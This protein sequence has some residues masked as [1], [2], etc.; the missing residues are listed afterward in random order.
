MLLLGLAG[1]APGV[2]FGDAGEFIAAAA[3]L[4]IAHAPG[5]PLF[6]LAAKAFGTVFAFGTWAL[7]VNLFSVL[8][9]AGAGAVFL[10]A[11]ARAGLGRAGRLFAVAALCLAPVWLHN[12]LQTEVFALNGLIAAVCLWI[13]VR[14]RE[15]FFEP[16]PAA[17][18][19]LALGLG[20]ANHQ[21]LIFLLP[22]ILI[23]AWLEERRN[24]G[25]PSRLR[26]ARF[27]SHFLGF[28]LLGL[29]VYAYLPIRSR[30]GPALDWGHPVDFPS[31]LHVLLRRDYGSFALTVQ[32]GETGGLPAPISQT[33]RFLAASWSGLGPVAASAALAGAA[34]SRGRGAA[35]PLALLLVAGPGFLIL[36][37]PPFDPI[38]AGAL[39]RF[40]LLPWFGAAWLAGLAVH[41]LAMRGVWARRAAFALLLAPVLGAAG[42]PAAWAQRWDLAAHDYGRNL[43][44]SLPPGAVL[45]ID[46]GDDSFYTLANLLYAERRRPD[47]E[48]HDR[49]GLVFPNAYGTQFRKLPKEAKEARRRFVES[50]MAD[51]GRAVFYATL[52]RGLLPDRALPIRGLL[53]R[54]GSAGANPDA[55]TEDPEG[56]ALWAVYPLRLSK[57]RAKQYYRY[58]ALIPFYAVM[59]AQSDESAGRYATALKRLDDAADLGGDAAWLRSTTAGIA[60]WIGFRASGEAQWAAAVAAYGLSAR[61]VGDRPDGWLNLGVAL[62][63]LGSNREAERAYRRAIAADDK[64]YRA[65]YNLGALY[66]KEENWPAAALA[67]DRAVAADPARAD[68]RGY[69]QRARANAQAGR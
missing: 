50:A 43:T 52:N 60:E 6:C 19:G 58:R 42:R 63:R 10:D 13:A 35:L 55:D 4:S 22:P 29:A 3:S 56:A 67:F 44:R 66:W 48:V 40:Y 17:A 49:G 46:G 32:G 14:W 57:A 12:T 20:G 18:F 69:A 7:R 21:T 25:N 59:R 16:R 39:E 37:N 26:L 47:L 33:L 38:T 15:R 41:A 65:W 31:F 2:S 5:Y 23:A 45:F 30:I 64:S 53:R 8:C 36:G 1:M 68:A 9:G 27:A 54:I 61:A 62:E 34:L 24:S 51:S 11:L 28:G